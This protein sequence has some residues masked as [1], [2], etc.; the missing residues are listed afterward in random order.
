MGGEG[1]REHRVRRAVHSAIWTY[2]MPAHDVEQPGGGGSE[3]VASRLVTPQ[4]LVTPCSGVQGQQT[5]RHGL[6]GHRL[7]CIQTAQSVV[8][9][10]R[11]FGKG[12]WSGSSGCIFIV[13]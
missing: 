12:C 2:K 5:S 6:A 8:Q 11:G 4:W 10:R 9:F 7:A 1:R 13:P 3:G